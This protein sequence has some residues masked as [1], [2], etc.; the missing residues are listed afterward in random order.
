MIKDYKIILILIAIILGSSLFG[1]LIRYVR[2]KGFFISFEIEC[3]E[4]NIIIKGLMIFNRNIEIINIKKIL[5]DDKN[6]I[7]IILNKINIIKIMPYI[8]N[9][10]EFEKYLSN[11]MPIE[12]NNKYNRYY[13]YQDIPEYLRIIPII[14][15]FNYNKI[16]SNVYSYILFMLLI[17]ISI[18]SS[19]RACMNYIKLRNK[20]IVILINI[21][22]IFLLF[23]IYNENK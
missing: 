7:Y 20:I 21:F 2:G 13:I 1:I 4:K 16:I 22:I 23:M 12:Q 17:I 8:E 15:I 5:K 3:N 18:Y 9:I 19:L 10:K 6:N 14:A 11:I